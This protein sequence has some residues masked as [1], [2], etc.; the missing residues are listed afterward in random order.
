MEPTRTETRRVNGQEIFIRHWGD[1]NLPP[2]LMLHGFPEYG[3]AW[4]DLA[5]LLCQHFHCIAPTSAA[6]AKA[7]RPKGSN[8]TRWRILWPIWP[9]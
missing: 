7:A 2:L 9:R 1:E 4:R 8:P 3:G 6:M 5:P